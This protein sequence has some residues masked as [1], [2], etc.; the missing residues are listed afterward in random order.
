MKT[1]TALLVL[2]FITA[3]S[4]CMIAQDISTL[5][6][7]GKLTTPHEAFISHYSWY[8]GKTISFFNSGSDGPI[9]I[10]ELSNGHMEA[11]YIHSKDC[12]FYYEYLH[13]TGTIVSWRFEGNEKT[14][15]QNPYT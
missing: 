2:L 15:I 3:L 11:E 14:C 5:A 12:R 8:V 13:E 1:V 4:G 6:T 10:R 9:H 7:N